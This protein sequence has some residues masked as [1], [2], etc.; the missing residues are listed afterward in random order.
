MGDDSGVFAAPLS[1]GS[2]NWVDC[3]PFKPQEQS[4]LRT[5]GVNHK[6]SYKG[7]IRKKYGIYNIIGVR[8]RARLRAPRAGSPAAIPKYLPLYGRNFACK[9][10][11]KNRLFF[12]KISPF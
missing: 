11:A 4:R 1:S 10:L 3:D 5:R 8:V 6:N 7:S 2:E 12:L 9:I